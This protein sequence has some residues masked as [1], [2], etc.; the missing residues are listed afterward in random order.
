MHQPQPA[1]LRA[2]NQVIADVDTGDDGVVLT[3]Y[4]IPPPMGHEPDG[5]AGA[6]SIARALY[7][8]LA[9]NPIIA[10]E[11]EAVEVCEAT[12]RAGRTTGW[13]NGLGPVIHESM[14]RLL[15]EIHRLRATIGAAVT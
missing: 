11:P 7:L 9:A 12:A 5:S 2:A 3:G 6:A 1:A 15:R 13:C 10:G 4:L 14:V 8:G